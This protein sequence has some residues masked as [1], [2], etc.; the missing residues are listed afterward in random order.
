MAKIIFVV[1][2]PDF[3]SRDP[4]DIHLDFLK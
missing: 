2:A 1:A 3:F 4:V